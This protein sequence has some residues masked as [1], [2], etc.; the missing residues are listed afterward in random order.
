MNLSIAG[1]VIAMVTMATGCVGLSSIELSETDRAQIKTVKIRA[2]SKMPDMFFHD[3]RKSLAFSGGLV[4]AIVAQTMYNDP[5]A[6]ILASMKN[7]KIDIP[8]IVRSEF[9]MAMQTQRDFQVVESHTSADAEMVLFVNVYGLG[10]ANGFSS[11]LYPLL[12]LSASLR[13]PDGTVVWQRTDHV[14]TLNK[15]NTGG[16][17]SDDYIR[18]PDLLRQTWSNAAG[19]VS[20]MLVRELASQN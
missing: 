12:N 19:I 9:S 13:K 3:E 5:E 6:Q 18:N 8:T 17:T 20:R 11:L 16:H 10:Q 4:G 7:N 2:D 1:C 14:G 15:E